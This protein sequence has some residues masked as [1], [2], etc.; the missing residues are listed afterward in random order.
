MSDCTLYMQRE[1][2]KEKRGREQRDCT[3][4]VFSGTPETQTLLT[5]TSAWQANGSDFYY[6]FHRRLRSQ[7]RVSNEG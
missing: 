5:V 6:L 7:G 3:I 4:C 1:R 2:E